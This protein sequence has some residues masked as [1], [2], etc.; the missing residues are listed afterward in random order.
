MQHNSGPLMDPARTVSES[1]DGIPFSSGGVLGTETQSPI[2]AVSPPLSSPL[3][4]SAARKLRGANSFANSSNL[5]IRHPMTTQPLMSGSKTYH[6]LRF[7][8]FFRVSSFPTKPCLQIDS[9]TS[10]EPQCAQLSHRAWP[11]LPCLP[12][13]ECV[14]LADSFRSDLC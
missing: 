10:P 8:F 2:L 3:F 4:A 6:Q 7:F 12:A 14:S 9:D 5:I 13:R 1:M 11:T